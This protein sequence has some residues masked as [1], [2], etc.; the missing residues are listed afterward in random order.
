MLVILFVFFN[1]V[2]QEEKGKERG[3]NRDTTKER[4]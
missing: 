4:T 2:V 3:R 1:G